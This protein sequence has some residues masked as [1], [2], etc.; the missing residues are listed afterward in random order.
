MRRWPPQGRNR[1]KIRYSE[2]FGIKTRSSESR[3]ESRFEIGRHQRALT[4]LV[5]SFDL[6]LLKRLMKSGVLSTSI[7]RKMLI[8]SGNGLTVQQR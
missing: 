7:P 3:F 8:V 2:K 5:A 4:T 1:L 6:S